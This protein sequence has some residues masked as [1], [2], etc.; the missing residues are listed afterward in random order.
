MKRARQ[1]RILFI[2]NTEFHLYV[3]HK[4]QLCE[5]GKL[6]SPCLGL[7]EEARI[8]YKVTFGGEGNVLKA[9]RAVVA[10][11]YVFSKNH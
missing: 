2:W 8:D 11:P 5:D 7:G 9:D 3:F 10:E 4:R 6:T 1:Q